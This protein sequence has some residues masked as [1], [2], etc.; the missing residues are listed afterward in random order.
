MTLLAEL[1]DGFDELD[2]LDGIIGLV[3]IK[4]PLRREVPGAVAVCQ[5]AGITIRMVT[6]DNILT[7]SKIA[8]ECGIMYGNGIALEGPIFRN[9]FRNIFNL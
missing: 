9:I 7:A 3:G 2:R 6:G 4:D 1:L 5:K 8:R